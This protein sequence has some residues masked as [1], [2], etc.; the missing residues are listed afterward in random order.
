[1]R[2]SVLILA[3]NIK[4]DREHKN[5]L[6][7]A[8]NDMLEL[9]RNSEHYVNSS[10]DFS[11]IRN[12]NKIRTK[13]SYIECISSNYVAFSNPD[14]SN[15]YFF[16]WIDKVN[17]IS[18]SCT[19]IEITIDNFAT[20][21]EF[22]NLE[23]CY[24]VREHPA[25]DYFGANN[26]AENIGVDNYIAQTSYTISAKA[27]KICF[28]F[29]EARKSDSSVE[30]PHYVSPWEAYSE[31]GGIPFI[32]GVPVTLWRVTSDVNNVSILMKYYNDYVNE[33]KGNDLVGVFFYNDDGDKEISINRPTMIGNYTPKYAKTLQYPFVKLS[34]SNNA[35]AFNELRFED[36]NDNVATF[37]KESINNYKGQCICFP[38]NYKNIENN[39]DNGLIIDNFPT[40]PL[41]VD[42]YAT[43]LAQNS[44]TVA[45]N[46]FASIAGTATSVATGN[47]LTAIAGAGG[48]INSLG[49]LIS[50]KSKPDS[51]VG[52]S[53]G[54]LLNMA[55]DKFNYLVEVEV[56]KED[57]AKSIDSFFDNYGYLVNTIKIPNVDSQTHNYV[58]I[59]SNAVAVSGSNVPDN[60]LAEINNSFVR[61]VTFW[62]NHENIGNYY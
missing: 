34:I 22:T 17:Y 30:N 59:S 56:C 53:S 8:Q 26:L 1:M 37:K 36:F 27:N 33:G 44:T 39:T 49:D 54:N 35:G 62:D 48:L 29:S 41:T 46:S 52:A 40:I 28:L 5:V 50:A 9:L 32:K 16:A 21:W 2:N 13:F 14:Y 23:K 4:L 12:I 60:S 57:V 58:Q 45:L 3:K 10:N 20:W 47:P 38:T 19:E 51:V 24:V 55:L 6:R 61:G 43:Y 11:F 31:A 15:I 25:Y 7:Y 18:N 42:S